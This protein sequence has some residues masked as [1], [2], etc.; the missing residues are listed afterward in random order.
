MIPCFSFVATGSGRAIGFTRIHRNSLA[1][2]A[3][4]AQSPAT[5]PAVTRM[6]AEEAGHGAR[7]ASPHS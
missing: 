2:Y 1:T 6:S 7:D 5:V 3:A 4:L